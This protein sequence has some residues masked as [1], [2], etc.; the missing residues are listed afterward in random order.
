MAPQDDDP[1]SFHLTGGKMPAAGRRSGAASPSGSPSSHG[2][3]S[4]A[5]PQRRGALARGYESRF[6][7]SIFEANPASSPTSPNSRK[8]AVH[9]FTDPTNPFARN[10]SKAMT[11][12][13]DVRADNHRAGVRTRNPCMIPQ[14]EHLG[15][16]PKM[17]A[18]QYGNHDWRPSKRCSEPPS[19]WQGAQS[20]RGAGA[21]EALVFEP[22]K[23]HSVL[24]NYLND[25]KCCRSSLRA[26]PGTPSADL[27]RMNAEVSVL[28]SD[29]KAAN[30][31]DWRRR[32]R[33][34]SVDRSTHDESINVDVYGFA[35]KR[36]G[37]GK[38]TENSPRNLLHHETR[39]AE[40]A[41]QRSERFIKADR[42]FEEVVAHMKDATPAMQKQ[43]DAFKDRNYD[44]TGLLFNNSPV[45]A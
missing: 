27:K 9:S 12:V 19:Q 37:T 35:R 3:P 32:S 42:R 33:S 15:D 16:R 38:W 24:E 4:E 18:Y 23:R 43:F 7:T 34:L 31:E 30:S 6:G 2:Y 26:V 14:R 11:R 39:S 45:V 21:A 29:R 41:P 10:Q 5:T 8:P 17:V 20:P 44:S 40:T 25:M 22:N 1:G 36:P 28:P 13:E